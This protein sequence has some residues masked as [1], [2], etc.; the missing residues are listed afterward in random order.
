VNLWSSVGRVIDRI[1]GSTITDIT[2]I[3][4]AG[5]SGGNGGAGGSV[6]GGGI[7]VIDGTD[8]TMAGGL[9]SG[10]IAR[11]GAGGNGGSGGN[12]SEGGDAHGGGLHVDASSAVALYRGSIVGNGSDGGAGGMGVIDGT[13]GSGDGGGAFLAGSG[14]VMH[15][16]KI[17]KNSASSDGS[18][19]SGSFRWGIK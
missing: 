10:D 12:G 14:S 4:E 8:A 2:P 3:G 6:D 9:I 16:T 13:D 19:I 1:Q 18:D 7:A 15:G 11:A 5:G 17:A